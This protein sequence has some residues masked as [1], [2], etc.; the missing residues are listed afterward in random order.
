MT[1]LGYQALKLSQVQKQELRLIIVC[2]HS[3]GSTAEDS[4]L[5][6]IVPEESDTA[7]YGY[8]IDG[9]ISGANVFIDQNYNFQQD[10]CEYTVY[11]YRW[12]FCY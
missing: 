2:T 11:S 3:N 4:V 5:V 1:Q 9:Y 7:F 10:S 12:L 6:R 8:V